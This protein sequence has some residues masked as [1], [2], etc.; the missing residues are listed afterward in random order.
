MHHRR[1]TRQNFHRCDPR[2]S[3]ERRGQRDQFPLEHTLRRHFMRRQVHHRFRLDT[4]AT[5]RPVNRRGRVLGIAFGG[6]AVDPFHQ[7]VDLALLQRSIIG[8]MPILRICEPWRHLPH[9]HRSL[10]RLRPRPRIFVAEQ[11]HRRNLSWTVTGLTVFL[12]NG[13]DVFVEGD[14]RGLFGCL[15]GHGHRQ[16]GKNEVQH[17]LAS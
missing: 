8:E 11:R 13:K 15:N 12:K 10:D 2:V 17:N 16:S 5:G 9:G 3:F 1:I 14:R 7:R 4:P 6:P